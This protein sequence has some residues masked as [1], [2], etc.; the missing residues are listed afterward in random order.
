MGIGEKIKKLR[1][2]N[3]LS[4]EAF[5]ESI[6]VSRQSII[7]YEKGKT[8]PHT[9]VLVLICNKYNLD[10]NYFIDNEVKKENK[11]ESVSKEDKKIFIKKVNFDDKYYRNEFNKDLK[12]LGINKI[13]I[14]PLI[15]LVLVVFFLIIDL[16]IDY[17][18]WFFIP[19]LILFFITDNITKKRWYLNYYQKKYNSINSSDYTLISPQYKLFY[20]EED[21]IKIYLDDELIYY[22]PN[23]KYSHCMAIV[24]KEQRKM[25]N[26][27]PD[28]NDYLYGL[29]IFNKESGTPYVLVFNL[30]YKK[31]SEYK[32]LN[33]INKVFYT[34]CLNDVIM[35]LNNR[36]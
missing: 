35:K 7:A 21:G 10:L 9:D 25:L 31:Y 20:K 2:S 3:N 27:Y 12:K 11:T 26:V 19:A 29:L 36:K 34:K 1:K 33:D 22:C 14:L 5:A 6:G 16:F 17:V 30:I 32:S 18:G 28:K 23:D 4:Q 8:I 13:R 15:F 24:N